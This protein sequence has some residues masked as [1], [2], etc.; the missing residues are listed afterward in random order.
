MNIILSAQVASLKERLVL[1]KER[2]D[3]S[4]SM[5][6]DIRENEIAM[7]KKLK[8]EEITTRDIVK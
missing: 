7:E 4:R 1:E 3:K 5:E 8:E 6:E 2:K